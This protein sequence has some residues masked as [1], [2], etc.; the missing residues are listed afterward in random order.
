MTMSA[1]PEGCP[2]AHNGCQ[3]PCHRTPGMFHLV[4]CC[5]APPTVDAAML[6]AVL[7]EEL[8]PLKRYGVT[9]SL[10][11]SHPHL[12][13]Y[14]LVEETVD[15]IWVMYVDYALLKKK[16]DTYKLVSD[17]VHMDEDAYKAVC[18]ERDALKVDAE[19]TNRAL[20]AAGVAAN[21]R[22]HQG[23]EARLMPIYERV[24]ALLEDFSRERNRATNLM[25]KRDDAVAKLNDALKANQFLQAQN[26][27]LRVAK[28]QRIATGG[29]VD[30]ESRYRREMSTWEVATI[31]VM[32]ALGMDPFA[33][34]VNRDQTAAQRDLLAT[35]TSLRL[36][37]Q[38]NVKQLAA[39]EDMDFGR[40]APQPVTIQC[41]KCAHWHVDE[42]KEIAGTSHVEAAPGEGMIGARIVMDTLPVNWAKHPHSTHMCAHCNHEWMPFPIKMPTVGVIPK[43]DC[44]TDAFK[45]LELQQALAKLAHQRDDARKELV[46][47]KVEHGKVVVER[48]SIRGLLTRHEEEI[49]PKT[50]ADAEAT[51]NRLKEC[52]HARIA[53]GDAG[54][55]DR[56]AKEKERDEARVVHAALM[57]AIHGYADEAG[58]GTCNP[59]GDAY[60][61][62]E[63]IGLLVRDYRDARDGRDDARERCRSANAD[64]T[65]LRGLCKDL[66]KER[67]RLTEERETPEA[68]SYLD[69]IRQRDAVKADRDMYERLSNER[70]SRMK[71]LA[72]ERDV[73]TARITEVLQER[74]R[75]MS[76][77]QEYQ[78]QRDQLATRVDDQGRLTAEK[79]LALAA[80]KELQEILRASEPK[81]KEVTEIAALMERMGAE[82][83]KLFLEQVRWIINE[84]AGQ[85][86]VH[87]T[88]CREVEAENWAVLEA[89]QGPN[90]SVRHAGALTRL[91]QIQCLIEDRDN[92]RSIAIMS[93][94]KP[95]SPPATALDTVAAQDKFRHQLANEV[96][97]KHLARTGTGYPELLLA[98]AAHEHLAYLSPTM[99]TSVELERAL[100]DWC[101]HRW[102]IA[103]RG[104]AMDKLTEVVTAWC[105]SGEGKRGKPVG[106]K[107]LTFPPG[108]TKRWDL[109]QYE[110]SSTYEGNTQSLDLNTP[111][112]HDMFQS[113]LDAAAKARAKR[114]VA[115]GGLWHAQRASAGW[116]D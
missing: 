102:G 34:Q 40:M 109:E 75:A 20:T 103:T 58:V 52:L 41:P 86:Q 62:E 28:D 25:S 114:M 92:W 8:P 61:P 26:D 49:L 43:G 116:E 93:G 89:L 95:E 55:A 30:W 7:D 94:Y 112:G 115:W 2:P 78:R 113:T 85:G 67:T 51:E 91:Q 39:F 99:P 108:T 15:G 73:A 104:P 72:K 70:L 65:T 68:T 87:S 54:W 21:P 27:R 38:A 106:P 5:T 110:N 59:D 64:V 79:E 101:M 1:A 4:A 76:R 22:R 42:D 37:N 23:E 9:G 77:E 10:G 60:G 66:E 29:E 57:V 74:D 107:P 45:V 90:S 47:L 81:Q 69:L 31:E 44:L 35:A 36:R 98:I 50:R 13:N 80:N 100:G 33:F 19:A 14:V 105:V 48:N 88:L 53:L 46:E 32:Q 84:L 3:C 82:G 56:D 12:A 17:T 24:V 63:R 83:D 6:Q 111:K 11:A 97:D 96:I 18:K 71:E 16:R